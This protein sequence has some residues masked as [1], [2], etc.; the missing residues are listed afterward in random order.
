MGVCGADRAP[1]VRG[2]LADRP[3]LRAGAEL[4]LVPGDAACVGVSLVEEVQLLL[5]AGGDLGV[6]VRRR[7]ASQVVP[8]FWAPMQRNVGAGMRANLSAGYGRVRRPERPPPAGRASRGAP[9]RRRRGRRAAS[10][11]SRRRGRRSRSNASW[12]GSTSASISP[13]S[14]ASATVWAIRSSHSSSTAAS[15][16]RTAPGRAA[17]SCEARAKKQPPGNRRSLE[18]AQPALEQRAQPVDAR[19][20]APAPAR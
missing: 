15:A 20:G 12:A 13:A 8:H 14:W 1:V 4:R 6:L 10:A 19:A 2:E 3:G 5:P 18:Y 16:S 7:C 9:A 17:Y 11:G